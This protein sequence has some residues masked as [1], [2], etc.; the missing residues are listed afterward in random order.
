MFLVFLGRKIH[1]KSRYLSAILSTELDRGQSGLGTRGSAGVVPYVQAYIRQHIPRG[2]L[3]F[4][5]CVYRCVFKKKNKV[6]LYISR[7]QTHDFT[8]KTKMCTVFPECPPRT[9]S[10]FSHRSRFS[11]LSLRFLHC[12]RL[13]VL[14]ISLTLTC[15]LRD[16][17]TVCEVLHLVLLRGVFR[18]SHWCVAPLLETPRFC[19]ICTNHTALVLYRIVP[20]GWRSNTGAKKGE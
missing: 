8:L 19:L 10:L 16:S 13:E 5:S 9:L 7:I 11:H 6:Q 15:R 3:S 1:F 18:T 12:C 4:G 20:R 17:R 2:S 14:D